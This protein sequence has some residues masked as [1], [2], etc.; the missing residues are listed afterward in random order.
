MLKIVTTDEFPPSYDD[1]AGLVLKPRVVETG[2]RR[3]YTDIPQAAPFDTVP[4]LLQ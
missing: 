3:K 1:R 4:T 2:D